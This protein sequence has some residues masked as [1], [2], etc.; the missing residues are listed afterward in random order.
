ML[1]I[2]YLF[3]STDGESCYAT[4]AVNDHHET[5]P[6]RSKGFRRWLVSK[7]Y[8]IE[9]KPPAAQAMTDA[10]GAIEARSQYSGNVHDVHVRVGGD[11]TAIYLDLVNEPWEVVKVTASGWQ[12]IA[13]PPLKFRRARAMRSLPRPIGGGSLHELRRFVNVRD[14]GQWS[15]LVA[16]LVA[17]L[18]GRGP[19][20]VL[21]LGGQHGSA[22]STTAEM[23]RYLIDPNTAMLRAEPR[24]PRDVAIAANN[25]LCVALDNIATLQ[26][27]LSDCLCRLATGGGFAT[28]ELFSDFDEAIF[29]AQRP[30]IVNGIE[31]VITRPD[32]LDRAILL[33][34]PPIEE[35]KRRPASVL[36]S[37]FE[38]ARP[39]LLGALLDAVAI[40]LRREK[41]IELPRLP[42]MADFAIWATAAAPALGWDDTHFLKVYSSNREQAHEV[43]LD[44]SPIGASVRA[45]AEGEWTGTAAELLVK[46]NAET[47]DATKKS[48]TWPATARKLGA[49]LRRIAPY[50]RAVGIKVEFSDRRDLGSRRRQINISNFAPLTQDPAE[51]TE[52]GDQ[53]SDSSNGS[54]AGFQDALAF[55]G[56]G[57]PFHGNDADARGN[58]GGNA[59]KPPRNNGNDGND[60]PSTLSD[61]A[62][63]RSWACALCGASSDEG[64]DYEAHEQSERHLRAGASMALDVVAMGFCPYCEP[65]ST[66]K[67][68]TKTLVKLTKCK[69][70]EHFHGLEQARTLVAANRT[71]EKEV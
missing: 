30:V 42:R 29:S 46:M 22:K 16:W 18:R 58:E 21:G 67:R 25:G 68:K 57:G 23:L 70:L 27:W 11:D 15:L 44:A 38:A 17:S 47:D 62:E 52:V 50:L 8:L 13:D 41:S 59:E 6:V 14:D 36:W 64:L 28:R 48:K 10:L 39:R 56:H 31:E 26:P 35:D 49:D 9:G 19:Y 2:E 69:D 55:P 53:R 45:I 66:G 4:V 33:D 7:F 24:N 65:I 51:Q 1:D 40:A 34:L 3:R 12:I 32:L 60:A 37:M 61:E 54:D 5:W 43:A 20:P 63:G 71:D